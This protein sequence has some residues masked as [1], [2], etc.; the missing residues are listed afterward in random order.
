MLVSVFIRILNMSLTGSVIILAMLVVRLCLKRA[1]RIF[2]YALWAV[3]LFRLLC[4]V[5]FSS[6]VSFLGLLEQKSTSQ[7]RMEYIS[8]DAGS[9]IGL[10]TP[11]AVS[12]DSAAQPALPA[13]N[14]PQP[15]SPFSLLLKAGSLTWILGITVMIIYSAYS[16]FL[17]RKRIRQAAKEREHIYRLPGQGTPFVYGVFRPRIYLS[18]T[19]RPEEETYILLHE[20]I[21]I[22][23]RDPLFRALAYLALCLHWFNPFVWLAFSLSGQDMEMSC[24]EAV[25]RQIGSSVKKKYSASL[26]ALA[27]G[28][29]MVKG[30][31][32][33]FG[34]GNTKERIQNILR[35]QKPARILSLIAALVCVVLGVQ[36]L[37]N[38][39]ANQ[40][41]D[42]A[43]P[44]FYGI[45]T[46]ADME[47]AEL[48]L[49]VRIPRLG[50]MAIP[51]ADLV[52]PY[53]EIDFDGL[54]AGDL[55]R[56]T[57]PENQE[58]SVME[59]YPGQFSEKAE[60]IEVMGRG[61]FA[62]HYESADRYRF[63]VPLG[64]APQAEPGDLLEI[65]HPAPEID[66]QEQELL[67]SIEVL[68][69]VP[70]QYQIW[71]NMS[72]EEVEIFLSEFASGIE[73]RIV[74]QEHN[75]SSE[76][77][78]FSLE[79]VEIPYLSMADIR[80][81]SGLNGIYRL[82]LISVSRSAWGIDRYLMDDADTDESGLPF[83]AFAED[84]VFEVNQSINAVSYNEVSFDDFAALAETGRDWINPLCT[85]HFEDNQI[86]QASLGS[87]WYGYG[88]KY[89][90]FTRD[91]WYSDIQ[92][93]PEMNG[94][95]PLATCYTLVR[96]EEADFASEY[97]IET[98]E[99]YTGNIGDG[100]SGIVLFK[101]QAGELLYSES[102][103]T[104]RAGWN[105]I[106]L[107]EV[108]GKA[109]LMTLHIEDRDT[110]GCYSYQVFRFGQGGKIYQYGGSSFSF[111]QDLIASNEEVFAMWMQP[112]T[113]YLEHSHLLL[114]TQD[115]EVRTEPVCESG[116]YS[117]EAL[118]K[119]F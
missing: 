82:N 104:A 34:E 105:N 36:F 48:P 33:A 40:N 47:G 64:M 42:S 12:S 93:F 78:G 2:S 23:R 119:E 80:S 79:D 85:L 81:E 18:Q 25:I 11:A 27:S 31:P 53:I 52:E 68:E 108:D 46:Y 61:L 37:A 41:K 24:D 7:G 6:N 21:H 65:Y 5:S 90:P 107:G 15:F 102:A 86:T 89:E 58:V 32:I 51:A 56:I 19:L 38:P 103:H 101:N 70:E 97:G 76:E 62:L 20:Q 59:T 43:K 10:E 35:Y 49:I 8:E 95:D 96:T 98:A 83:L 28:H 22:R 111:N 94:R 50:D 55:I 60:K 14:V 113:S 115:G 74:K 44:V 1:P 109:F 77:E 117:Y 99:I 17:L 88:V 67:S 30:L 4:P 39:H 13:Q 118:R 45:V 54:E 29:P 72:T 116:K 87:A 63:T 84:C 106:Y 57:F 91:T 110:F 3:V 114:S 69:V 26:L 16:L 66:G 112:L 71:V 100:D 73:C 9:R 92:K 75:E